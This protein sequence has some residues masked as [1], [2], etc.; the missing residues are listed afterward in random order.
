MAKNDGVSRRSV[1]RAGGLGVLAIGAGLAAGGPAR[2]QKGGKHP[3]IRTAITE[4][5]NARGYLHDSPNKFG[6]H[7]KR[8]IQAIDEAIEQ[9]ETCLKY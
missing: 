2:A 7:K 1:L 3:K 4:L 8:A 6:G 9:L 5:R